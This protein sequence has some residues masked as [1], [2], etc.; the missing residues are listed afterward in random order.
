[1]ADTR[2]FGTMVARINR[3]IRRDGLTADV[4]DAIVD[5]IHY[6]EGERFSFNETSAV[7]V[8]TASSPYLSSLPSGLIQLDEV[9]ID[10]GGSRHHLD[11][12]PYERLTAADNGNSTGPPYQYALYQGNMRLY[13]VP[14][15]AYSIHL[16][17]QVELSEVSASASAGATN[18]WMTDAEALIRSRAKALVFAHRL[19][20][21]KEA[22]V[23]ENVANGELQKIKQ[24]DRGRVAHGK[25]VKT[26]F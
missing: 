14:D 12:W 4:K 10:Q 23:M 21:T 6:Y 24:R 26:R 17:Y 1:M 25:V 7:V 20:N 15:Q 3:E 22:A 8:T 13:P 9:E 19:R 2:T 5:A 11:P 18:A 16:S